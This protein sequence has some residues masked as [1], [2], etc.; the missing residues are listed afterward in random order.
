M[1]EPAPTDELTR[2]E[3]YELAQE[4][5]IPGRSGM[6]KQELLEALSE[7]SREP[8]PA[9][10]PDDG[11]DRSTTSSRTIWSGHISFG[12]VTIPVGLYAAVEDRSLSFHL[13]DERDGAR[14]RYRKV[15]E[16]TGEEIAPQHIV[17]GYPVG[18]GQHVTFSD[19]ELD[20]IPGESARTIDVI[21][22]V[23]P[24]EVDPMLLDRSYFVAPG[25]GGERAYAV[26]G[27]AMRA[28]GLL[29][30]AKVTLRQRE[31]LA[32]LRADDSIL[33]LE[34]LHWPDE[35]RIPD[36]ETGPATAATAEQVAMA[37]QLIEQMREPF[38]PARYRD[39][40]R[41][42]LEEAVEAKLAGEEVTLAPEQPARAEV[43]DL[44]EVLRRSVEESRKRESA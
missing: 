43:V 17:K 39:T 38:Q 28:H 7:P 5:E 26:L 13:L 11:L 24:G 6:T 31:H 4:R 41:E 32:A 27:E 12:L 16:R 23:E 21:Q 35:I 40:Y 29:A 33:A 2:D 19:E 15:N 22:F 30:V 18:A 10:D 14:V 1:P 8:E 34:T 44:T 42:R 20:R 3:L 9:P 36:F 25:K 37:E